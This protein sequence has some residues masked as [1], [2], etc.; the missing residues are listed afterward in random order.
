MLLH[1]F[2]ILVLDLF[3]VVTVALVRDSCYGLGRS[4]RCCIFAKAFRYE[5]LNT[6]ATNV[7]SNKPLSSPYLVANVFCFRNKFQAMK[8]H[9]S[10]PSV[11]S[12]HP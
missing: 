8:K 7:A 2:E 12:G 4:C 3:A 9:T 10:L 6:I 1:L 11:K 5:I